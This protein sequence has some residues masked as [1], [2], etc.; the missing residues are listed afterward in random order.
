MIN[1]LLFNSFYPVMSYGRV[2]M[3]KK[4]TNHCIRFGYS[5]TRYGPRTSCQR[6]GLR[7]RDRC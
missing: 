2:Q 4:A 5:V 3:K 7:E 1:G 6:K